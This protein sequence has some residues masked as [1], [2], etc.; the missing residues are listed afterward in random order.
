MD[1]ENDSTPPDN[2]PDWNW[3]VSIARTEVDNLIA[4]LPEELREPAE[5]LPVYFETMPDPENRRLIKANK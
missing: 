2:L 1:P 5:R 3:L 4:A